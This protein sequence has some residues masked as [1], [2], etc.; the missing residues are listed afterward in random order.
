MGVGGSFDVLAEKM[1][2][3]L[4]FF[5]KV[6]FR[7]VLSPNTTAFPLEKNVVLPAIAIKIFF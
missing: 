4:S 6:K 7:M 5:A 1:R 3:E 2:K